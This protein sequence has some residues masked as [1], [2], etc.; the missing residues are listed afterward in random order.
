M[1]RNHFSGAAAVGMH[2]GHP[3]PAGWGCAM[4]PMP[5]P[6][7]PPFLPPHFGPSLGMAPSMSMPSGGQ[8]PSNN[9]T[10]TLDHPSSL[11]A[12]HQQIQQQYDYHHQYIQMQQQLGGC[13]MASGSGMDGGPS[14]I[15]KALEVKTPPDIIARQ[16]GSQ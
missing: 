5:P 11:S 12:F 8:L 3:P 7:Y 14:T 9:V 16:Q 6:G 13:F 1:C 4:P 2:Y 10:A 15:S